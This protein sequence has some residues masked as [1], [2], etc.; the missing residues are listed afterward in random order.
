MILAS[1][2][3]AIA[4]FGMLAGAMR[5]HAK[6][7]G[8]Q[9]ATRRLRLAGWILLV[10]SYIALVERMNWRI[11]AIAWTGQASLAAAISVA[12]LS[13]KTRA[14]AL[15]EN[16]LKQVVRQDGN[17]RSPP[18]RPSPAESTTRHRR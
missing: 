3:L 11:A 13:L 18:E 10:A 15:P 5:R 6:Q 16:R 4:G 8:L 12:L 7:I 2:I 9:A 14:A 17:R 1:F